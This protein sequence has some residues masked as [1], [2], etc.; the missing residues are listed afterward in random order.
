MSK[1]TKGSLAIKGNE[2]LFDGFVSPS[3]FHNIFDE[4]LTMMDRVWK[5]CDITGEA[6]YA[7][8]PQKNSLP[9]VNVSETDNEYEVSVA[10]SGFSKND[11]ELEFKDSCLLVK[12]DSKK[13]KEDSSDEEDGSKRWLTREIASRSFRRAINFPVEID[14][15]KIKSHFDEDKSLVICTLPKKAKEESET[16]KIKIS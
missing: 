10:V 4:M 11:V 15:S 12:F 13:E 2:G 5:T 1:Y 3:R 9:K 6:F 16:L 7:I 14:K 8:Q